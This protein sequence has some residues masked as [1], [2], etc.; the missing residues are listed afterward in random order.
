M[1][2]DAFLF[3]SFSPNSE[4]SQEDARA[5]T[6]RSVYDINDLRIDDIE[7][8]NQ[9]IDMIYATAKYNYTSYID[10]FV[11]VLPT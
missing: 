3:S 10:K 11:K 1:M 8:S 2:R 4:P 5:N 9:S 7:I 6:C